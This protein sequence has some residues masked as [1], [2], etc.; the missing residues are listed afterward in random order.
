[1]PTRQVSNA[2]G[3]NKVLSILK[4]PKR[5]KR[6]NLLGVSYSFHP[7]YVLKGFQKQRPER[8]IQNI[9]NKMFN[10]VVVET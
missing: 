3:G 1:M 8:K 9:I 2:F 10:K 5:F 4:L 7:E 6:I